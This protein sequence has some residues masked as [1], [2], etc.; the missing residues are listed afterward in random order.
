MARVLYTIPE[1]ARYL[2]VDIEDINYEIE[3]KKLQTVAIGT[4]LRI[5]N[6]SLQAFLK[7]KKIPEKRTTHRWWFYPAALTL[8][9]TGVAIAME[10]PF[11]D[12]QAQEISPQVALFKDPVVSDVGD[13]ERYAPVN[14]PLDYRRF[15]EAENPDGRGFTHTL[16]SLQHQNDLEPGALSF[17]WTLFINLDTNHDRG[18]GVGSIINLHNRGKG[19]A[20]GYHVDSFAWNEGTTLGSNIEMLD[21]SGEMAYTVG[22][23]IQNKAFRGDIGLQVQVGPLADTHPLWQAGM[24][25]S[26]QTGIKLSG[27]PGFAHFNTGI[28]LGENTTGDR[29][30]WL[31]GKYRIGVDI[32]D[33]DLRMN[34]GSAIELAGDQA[35]GLR[36]NDQ[37]QRI[38]FVSGN[39]V[40]AFLPSTSRDVNLGR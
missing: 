16:M 33:N 9:I 11:P 5:T 40:I 39:Q 10:F 17:P 12:W 20:T 14:A 28:E 8:F 13:P 3:Q 30:V 1:V 37:Q 7:A 26:W 35:I 19:W 36:F 6:D 24:D 25:G 27:Q 21:M 23:N 31:R 22:M 18:D 4:K 32:G 38:E 15:N 34:A 29:G 2:R